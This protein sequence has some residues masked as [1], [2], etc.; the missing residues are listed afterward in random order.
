M[1]CIVIPYRLDISKERI[2]LIKKMPVYIISNSSLEI[3]EKV[4]LSL[5]KNSYSKMVSKDQLRVW[6]LGDNSSILDIKKFL[7]SKLE[8]LNSDTKCETLYQI[9]DLQDL[10]SIF[11]ILLFNIR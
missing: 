5:N 6:R 3:K 9:P 7:L 10:E 8:E 4:A 11:N 1:Q 2:E